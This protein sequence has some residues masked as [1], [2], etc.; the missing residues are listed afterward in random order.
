MVDRSTR[1]LWLAV[2]LVFSCVT[3]ISGGALRFLADRDL[4]TALVTGASTFAGTATLGV[5]LLSF[6]LHD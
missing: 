5:V 1:A 3:G 2:C 6:L 4:A